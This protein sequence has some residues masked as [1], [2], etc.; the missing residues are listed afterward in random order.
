MHN[1]YVDNPWKICVHREMLNIII[2]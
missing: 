1:V 2:Q